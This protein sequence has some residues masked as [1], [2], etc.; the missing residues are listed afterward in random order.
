M[1]LDQSKFKE[2]FDSIKAISGP[3]RC[4]LQED[5]HDQPAGKQG[6]AQLLPGGVHPAVVQ[7][8][9]RVRRGGAARMLHDLHHRARGEGGVETVQGRTGMQLTRR[10]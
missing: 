3:D 9:R 4:G 8:E 7:H 2:R 10:P 5:I 6:R 1:L